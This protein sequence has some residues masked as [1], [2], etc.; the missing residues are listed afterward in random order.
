LKTNRTFQ[1][2][3]WKTANSCIHSNQP[4]IF[5]DSIRR[6]ILKVSRR[7]MS[8]LN[9][10]RQT[11]AFLLLF[12]NSSRSREI[13]RVETHQL[14][15]FTTYL[16][17]FFFSSHLRLQMLFSVMIYSD[18]LELTDHDPSLLCL[19]LFTWNLERDSYSTVSS[20]Q[21]LSVLRHVSWL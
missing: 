8:L 6:N 9:Y 12:L 19:R 11:E 4:V 14:G 20:K 21:L 17:L 18:G 10:C 5:Q 15:V 2:L 7:E 1:V 16:C 3:L 13:K